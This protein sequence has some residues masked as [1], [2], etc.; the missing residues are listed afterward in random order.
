MS[1][2][3]FK[4]Q[5]SLKTTVMMLFFLVT[6]ALG[7]VFI[8]Q[9]FTYSQKLTYET[10]NIKM[11]GLIDA[12]KES[13]LHQETINH[14][15]INSIHANNKNRLKLYTSILKSTPNLYAV[16]TGYSNGGFYEIINLDIHPSLRKIYKAKKDDR[17]LLVDIKNSISGEKNII[18]LNKDLEQ[19][20][21]RVEKNEY[22][23]RK[24]VW[25]KKAI[26]T[27]S[28]IKTDPYVFS[29]IPTKGITY[30]KKLEF[31]EDVIAID[32]L[33]YDVKSIFQKVLTNDYMHAYL[34]DKNNVTISTLND[35]GVLKEFL[36][37]KNSYESLSK[38][39]VITINNTKY[40]AQIQPLN[41]K[42]GEQIALFANYNEIIKPHQKEMY[43]MLA[44]FV[45]SIFIIIPFVIYMSKMIVR[46]IYKLIKQSQ[47]VQNRDFD[48]IEVINT[49]ILEVL[50]LS[51]SMLNMSKSIHSY[52][53]S[54]EEKVKQ[55]TQE[56]SL[57]NE[58]LYKLSITDKLTGLNNRVHLDEVLHSEFNRSLRYKT[59]FCVILMDIDFFKKVNDNYGH[60]VG[61]DVLVE[62]ARILK[63]SIRVNDTIG[64]WGGEE[65][66]IICPQTNIHGAKQVAQNINLTVKKHFYETYPKRV[67]MS[68]GVASFSSEKKKVDEIIAQADEALYKAKEQGRDQ[69]VVCE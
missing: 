26:N 48:N 58:E 17:W 15:I 45:V 19:T 2:S 49:P 51:K 22:D 53:T 42:N 33:L 31:S 23:P 4:R 64:R 16:Y 14:N 21:F 10:I 29:N 66:L 40:L 12:S 68:L 39:K 52:Q 13:M 56:L 36:T 55:R 65:F 37:S 67:T 60:Q 30:A 11:E 47:K 6:L 8:A 32:V 34:F 54:L 38:P 61:D 62:T 7:I 59:P 5:I 27:S 20:A 28:T 35:N 25:Y 69:V 43:K 46:P 3:I 9:L 1:F 63:N 44:I 18:L 41:T 57:K 24:R 50:Q